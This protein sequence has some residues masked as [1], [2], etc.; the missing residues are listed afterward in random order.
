MP[1]AVGLLDSHIAAMALVSDLDHGRLTGRVTP[2][3]LARER[4]ASTERP[5]LSAIAVHERRS[6]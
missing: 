1:I 2:R 6:R 5:S 3:R 4:I